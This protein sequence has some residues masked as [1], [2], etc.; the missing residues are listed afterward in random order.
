MIPDEMIE[1][2]RVY[3]VLSELD[4]EQLKKVLPLAEEAC[5][6]RG[7]ILFKEGDR[8]C[9]LYLIVSGDVALEMRA[10]DQV[11]AVQ[12]AHPGDT[13]G[14][15]A[16]SPGGRT[17]F[18]ARALSPVQAVAFPG[19]RLREACDRD[20]EMGYALTKQLLA[21]V[22]ERLDA[23]RMQLADTYLTRAAETPVQS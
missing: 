6:H 18:Q 16:L 4:P 23:A 21:L 9:F 13:I 2:A 8:S 15:S 14:W 22:T 1:F 12:I 20:P 5:F 19:D 3:R 11:F 17:H 10:G 7:E